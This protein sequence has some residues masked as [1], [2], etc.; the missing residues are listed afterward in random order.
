MGGIVGASVRCRLLGVIASIAMAL[1]WPAHAQ[2]PEQV[3]RQFLE[4]MKAMQQAQKQR[5][6]Q[7]NATQAPNA[8]APSV[9]Y[10][11]GGIELGQ[12]IDLTSG[13]FRASLV[14]QARA[15]RVT[16]TAE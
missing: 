16:L 7:S 11:V 13:Q 14:L 12:N 8:G 5:K 2:N 1:P 10:K 9:R 3:F 15:I 4:K 6:E